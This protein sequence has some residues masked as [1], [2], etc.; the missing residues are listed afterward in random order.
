M[1]QGLA[2]HARRNVVAY[3]ALGVALGA[4]GAVSRTARFRT[5]RA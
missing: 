1:L 3:L 5:R 2:S 4:G